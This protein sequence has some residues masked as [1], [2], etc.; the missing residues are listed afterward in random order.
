MKGEA[1]HAKCQILSTLKSIG[2]KTSC[3][4]KWKDLSSQLSFIFSI[5][6]VEQLSMHKTVSPEFN[7]LLIKLVP[8]NPIHQ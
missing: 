4:I 5:S 6:P 1:G 2:S 7:N 3:F 8:K